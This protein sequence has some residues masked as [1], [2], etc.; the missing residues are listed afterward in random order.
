MR[1]TSPVLVLFG[2]LAIF[3]AP[4]A[5][6]ASLGQFEVHGVEADDF[7]KMRT[8][9]GTD[10]GVVLG[11][12]NGTVLHVYDCTQTGSTRWCR[13]ALDKGRAIKGWVSWAY[14]RKL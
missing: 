2:L 9:P 14:L 5:M 7:L 1:L 10:Y 4:P 13:V 3:A 6:A 8:G 12:P 11:L